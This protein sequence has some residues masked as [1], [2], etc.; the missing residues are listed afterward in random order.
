[1]RPNIEKIADRLDAIE[2][3][4]NNNVKDMRK[5]FEE[6][7]AKDK[8]LSKA[9]KKET[10]PIKF[11]ELINLQNENLNFMTAYQRKLTAKPEPVIDLDTYNEI[12]TE[13]KSE[14]DTLQG[15]KVG[16][17]LEALKKLIPLMNGYYKEMIEIERVYNGANR[18][19]N[20]YFSS[21][22]LDHS[23]IADKGGDD[24]K[25]LSVFCRAYFHFADE[26]MQ[27]KG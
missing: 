24:S 13:I 1:M 22:G 15:E 18:L 7:I 21:R 9:L 10:D 8:Q 16:D 20:R 5:Q 12:E 11:N 4:Y 25:L 6:Y 3:E 19:A 26:F 14:V 2:T 27:F 17:I 23:K